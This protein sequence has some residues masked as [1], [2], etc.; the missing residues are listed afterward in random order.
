[1]FPVLGAFMIN[2]HPTLPNFSSKLVKVQQ[3]APVAI[4][5][6]LS[7]LSSRAWFGSSDWREIGCV[8]LLG[9]KNEYK[10]IYLPQKLFLSR[11][12]VRSS[13]C[14]C[15]FQPFSSHSA[16]L[17]AN[18]KVFAKWWMV[19]SGMDSGN[20][21]NLTNSKRWIRMWISY[22][23]EPRNEEI[24]AKEGHPPLRRNLCSW[25]IY[26]LFQC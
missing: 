21:C 7:Y 26:L 24:N 18:F 15:F 11:R 2:F 17:P 25:E 10:M 12:T 3:Y 8:N 22:S 23:L 19:W 5:P 13:N 4:L 9:R 16:D 6:L 1:M 20:A 14:S